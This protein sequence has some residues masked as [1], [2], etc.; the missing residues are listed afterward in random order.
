MENSL[1]AQVAGAEAGAVLLGSGDGE[2]QGRGSDKQ[3]VHTLNLL[4]MNLHAH[5]LYAFLFIM[6]YQCLSTTINDNNYP[7]LHLI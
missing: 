4:C 7:N 6:M 5:R 1:L 2:D 3:S